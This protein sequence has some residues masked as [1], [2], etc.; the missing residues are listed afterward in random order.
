MSLRSNTILLSIS[1]TVQV[2]GTLV[3]S[4]GLAHILEDKSDY[5]KFQ[6][7]FIVINFVLSL[8]S[9][10]PLGLSYFYGKYERFVERITLYKRFFL[11]TLLAAVACG[12]IL[13]FLRAYFAA[14]FSNE[15]FN[16]FTLLVSGILAFKIINSFFVN[17]NLLAK[18]L[19]YH[20]IISLLSSFAILVVL[21]I[22]YLNS[23]EVT[24]FIYAIFIIEVCKF[25]ALG[26]KIIKYFKIGTSRLLATKSELLY[27]VPITGVTLVTTL[28]MYADKY[29]I[30]DMLNPNAYADYQ[31]GAFAIPFISIITGSVITA[32]IPKFSEL[33]RQNNNAELLRLWKNAT[34]K[35]TVLL[36]PIFIY[37]IIFGQELI[38]FLYS[39]T[40]TLGGE[41]FQVYSI[42]Y[43]FSVILFGLTMSAIGLQNLVV[44]N[45]LINLI[46]NVILN[47]FFIIYYGVMGAVYATVISSLLGYILP[48]Y[49]VN[50][51]LNARITDYFPL[52]SYSQV[53]IVSLLVALICRAIFY[54]TG[55]IKITAVIL[56]G[57]YYAIVIVLCEKYISQVINFKRLIEKLKFK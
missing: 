48:V 34:V 4:V 47:Y 8:T 44:V 35:I 26:I 41:I 51:R 2:I 42:R 45:S 27:I 49:M 30:S 14:S 22:G 7:L 17:F 53:F 23:Y 52:K 21:A 50:K 1:N 20:F 46:V 10:I 31:V 6:Q 25:F 54:Y 56:S 15:Y 13:Y 33:Y 39:D 32:L 29:M 55:S 5:G 11:T 28:N 43:L 19:A 9:G 40:Y 12:I 18:N 57:I 3:L 38:T 24:Q 36:L 16:N 37:C